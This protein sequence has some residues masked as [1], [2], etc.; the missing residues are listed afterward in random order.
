LIFKGERTASISFCQVD[1]NANTETHAKPRQ[2]LSQASWRPWS[3]APSA[4]GT[5]RAAKRPKPTGL[6]ALGVTGS[7][8]GANAMALSVEG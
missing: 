2:H 6:T 3:L 4:R 1:F 5:R 7:P 8:D